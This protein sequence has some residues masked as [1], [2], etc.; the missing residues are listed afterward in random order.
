MHLGAGMAA[1]LMSASDRNAILIA[2]KMNQGHK[3]D[4]KTGHWIEDGAKK[5]KV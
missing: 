1:F 4:M 5:K 2:H 3:I